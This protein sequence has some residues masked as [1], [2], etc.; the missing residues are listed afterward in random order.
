MRRFRGVFAEVKDG[1]NPFGT[2]LVEFVAQVIGLPYHGMSD[3][4]G[5]VRP[6]DS[7][8]KDMST[9]AENAKHHESLVKVHATRATDEGAVQAAKAKG[10]Q[11]FVNRS[12]ISPSIC[13][14]RLRRGHRRR[15]LVCG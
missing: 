15:C 1:R 2:E 14:G 3:S 8:S 11:T 4:Q 10:D 5:S 12:G 7:Q 13:C 9:N 6:G